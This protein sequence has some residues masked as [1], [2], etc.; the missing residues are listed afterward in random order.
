MLITYA[1]TVLIIVHRRQVAVVLQAVVVDLDDARVDRM[2]LIVAVP[3][4]RGKPVPVA[5]DEVQGIGVIAVT[6]A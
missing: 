2:G 1:I 5:I 3:A 4:A 6:W